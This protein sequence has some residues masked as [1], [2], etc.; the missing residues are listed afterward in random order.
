MIMTIGFIVFMAILI[1]INPPENRFW[2]WYI[3]IVCLLAECGFELGFIVLLIAAGVWK[4]LYD[5]LIYRPK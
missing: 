3:L 1:K 4:V 2:L 5:L